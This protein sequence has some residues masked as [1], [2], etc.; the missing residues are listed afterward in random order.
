MID[1]ETLNEYINSMSDKLLEL[2]D[3]AERL[4]RIE[5]ELT[6]IKELLPELEV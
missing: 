2:H 4:E 5:T 1:S 3:I 6:D